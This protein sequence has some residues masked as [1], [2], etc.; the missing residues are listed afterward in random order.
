MYVCMYER[1]YIFIKIMNVP[2][3][4]DPTSSEAALWKLRSLVLT[5]VD[6]YRIHVDFK[7]MDWNQ[8]KAVPTCQ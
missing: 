6:L 4:D 3:P 2:H 5:E 8:R 1:W 7:C